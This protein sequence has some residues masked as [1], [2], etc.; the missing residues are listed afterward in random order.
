[1][2]K[3][4]PDKGQNTTIIDWRTGT[5]QLEWLIV[6]E[7]GRIFYYKKKERKTISLKKSSSEGYSTT[8]RPILTITDKEISLVLGNQ[9]AATKEA[10]RSKKSGGIGV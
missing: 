5:N 9:E 7:T 6:K 8:H 2:T 1:M 3:V 4:A 10:V